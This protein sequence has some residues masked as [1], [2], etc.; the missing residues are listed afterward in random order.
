MFMLFKCVRLFMHFIR[1][2]L[3]KVFNKE[4]CSCSSNLRAQC[5]K[6]KA[7]NFILFL[8]LYF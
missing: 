5:F 1:E 7:I 6:V 2:S 3:V 8:C 4:N